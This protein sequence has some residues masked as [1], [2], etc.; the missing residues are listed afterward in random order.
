[1]SYKAPDHHGN[2]EYRQYMEIPQSQVSA[3]IAS[4]EPTV[5]DGLVDFGKRRYAQL[6]Y[7]VNPVTLSGDVIIDNSGVET[8]IDI[9]NQLLSAEHGLMSIYV[10]EDGNLTWHAESLPGMPLSASFWRAKQ[11]EQI[12]VS[13]DSSTTRITWANGNADFINQGD[14]ISSL[15]YF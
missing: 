11:I 4:E 12:E 6:V 3:I 5:P 8:R 2:A 15:T 14:Q 13:Q 7:T 10:I 9:T 1:M